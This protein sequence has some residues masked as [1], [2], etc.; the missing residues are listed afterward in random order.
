M[1]VLRTEYSSHVRSIYG[2]KGAKDVW[3][4]TWTAGIGSLI[5]P[6]LSRLCPCALVLVCSCAGALVPLVLKPPSRMHAHSPRLLR[7][8]HFHDYN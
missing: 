1:Y 2:Y 3:A 5:F 8:K 7:Y 6:H 4:N